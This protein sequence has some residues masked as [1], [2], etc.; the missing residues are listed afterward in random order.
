MGMGNSGLMKYFYS[1][2]NQLLIT[3]L[4]PEER[5]K[6]KTFPSKSF[7]FSKYNFLI[8]LVALYVYRINFSKLPTKKNI[9]F[10]PYNI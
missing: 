9:N 4:V 2:D 7:E 1:P 3:V 6:C 5:C 10:D 8:P